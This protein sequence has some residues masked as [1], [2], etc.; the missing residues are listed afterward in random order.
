MYIDTVPNRNSPPA[1]LLRESVRRGARILKRTLANLSH[2]PPAKVD[3]LRRVLRDEPLAPTAHVFAIERSLPHGHV[4]AVLGTLRKLGLD[5]LL[6][7]KRC[8][9]RDL[10]VALIVERLLAPGSKLAAT[11]TWHSS[12]LAEELAV[13]DASED[14]VYAA[15]DWLL[16][17]QPAI[18]KKLAAR[19]LGEGAVAL[20]DVSS[21]FYYGQTCPLAQYG[22]D[23]DGT[24]GLPIIVYGVLADGEGRPVSVQVYP[25]NTGDPATIPAQVEKVRKDFG[26]ARVTLVG[27]RGML[28]ETRLAVLKTYP[29][30]GW[31]SALRSPAIHKL[32]EN[33]ALQR[34]L[35]DTQNLAEIAS[36]DFPGE[37]LIACHNP[38]L[39]AARKRTRAAL[40]AATEKALARLERAVQRRTKKPL[41][42]AEIGL[43]AGKIIQRYKVAKHF[44]L[45]IRDGAFAFARNA[46]A[47]SQ[48]E[49]LDGIYV[50]RTSETPAQFTAANTVR[51]YK[52]LAEVERAFRCLKGP[53][54][55]IRPI[56]H[57]T[58][59]H[60]RAHIFLCLLAYYVEW[61]MRQA[62]AP[63]L[64]EDHEVGAARTTRDPVAP[65]EPS[66]AARH[67]RAVRQTEDGLPVHSF[68]TL[69]KDM[70]TLCRNT[71]RVRA[72]PAA[73]PCT[74]LTQPTPLQHKVFKLLAL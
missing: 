13:Q 50:I 23:R 38:L 24:H 44:Q 49:I 42:A 43:R 55:L 37:R 41:S 9:A 22:H 27:D 58:D 2:W 16:Q 30:I 8:R 60:V 21:S 28:T 61:H 47:I 39:D 12:T 54:L 68:R 46:A 15:L 6:A 73:L 53:D 1:I 26:L 10:V 64:F 14:E 7:A 66:L 11:R 48:E 63:M 56:H 29:G 74:Q 62:L 35:F 65:A 45:T 31:I 3:A 19:H 4:Q 5:S 69:L 32:L 33:G 20:Y 18:E 25:G 51:T 17:R 72:D 59:A 34:S 70:A 67:K 57:R 52:R 36:P 71:C 40:L